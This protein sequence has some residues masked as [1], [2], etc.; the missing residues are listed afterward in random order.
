MPLNSDAYDL[1]KAA[2]PT[3]CIFTFAFKVAAF[4]L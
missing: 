3:V 2:H 1:N 4:I